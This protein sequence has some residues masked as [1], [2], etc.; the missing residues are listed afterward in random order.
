MCER[1]DVTIADEQRAWGTEETIAYYRRHRRAAAD[2]YPSERFFLPGVVQRVQSVLDVGCAAG[3]FNRVVKEFN[4]RIRYVGVDVTSSLIEAARADHPD[5]EFMVGD[6][7]HFGSP[8]ESYDLVHASGVLHLNLRY[9]DIIAAMWTQAR[10]FLLCD[11]RLRKGAG[12]TGRMVLPFGEGEKT[13]LRYIVLD[14][15]DAVGLFTSLRPRPSSLLV[16]GYPH[17]ASPAAGLVNPD[18][19]MAFF[20]AEKGLPAGN[21]RVEVDLDV[22]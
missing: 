14:V 13:L 18:V 11:L 6:G 2:L 20:L 7:V 15:D 1:V 3:G 21:M 4:P 5:A 9:K 19:H 17:R 12:E 10:R 16:K 22:R 8:P